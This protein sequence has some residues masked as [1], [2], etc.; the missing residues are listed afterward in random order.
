M[1]DWRKEYRKCDH[2]RAEYRPKRQGQEYCSPR[3][4]RDASYGRERFKAGTKGKRRRRIEAS[5]KLAATPLAGS[6]RNGAFSSRE[7]IACKPTIGVSDG[8][9]MVWPETDLHHGPTPG[10]LQGDDYPLE[11]Y[12]DGYPK[13]PACLDRR[14]KIILRRAA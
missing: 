7:P 3:C 2:C 8:P 14:A 4:R 13:L 5:D 1:S 12:E 10:A 6:F 9:T 11:Y